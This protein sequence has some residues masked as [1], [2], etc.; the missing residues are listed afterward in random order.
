MG[1]PVVFQSD[2]VPGVQGISNTNDGVT[3][4]STSAFGVFA[5]SV[6]GIGLRAVSES[7]R[8]MEAQ[9]KQ[10]IAEGLVA[11]SEGGA[12]VLGIS[13]TGD[14]VVGQSNSAFGAFVH[15]ESG[16][17]LRATSQSGR[18]M[19]AQAKQNGEG[20]VGQSQG[21]DG[22]FGIS[23]T[24]VGVHGQGGRLAGLFE[25]DVQATGNIQ[26]NDVSATGKI[27]CD[28][29]VAN[30]VDCPTATITCFDVSIS[31][32]DCAEEFE[33]AGAEAV[34]PGTLMSFGIDGTLFPSSES[35]DS[36]VVGVISGAG[37]YKPGIVLDRRHGGNRVPIAL[38]GKVYCK[39]DAEYSAIEVG[40][41]LTT[42][43]TAGH[44]MKA[45]DPLKAFGS[46]IGKALRSKSDGRGMIPVLV[47]LQ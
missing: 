39:V 23:V 13:N 32:A 46:V 15:S 19:E 3:G 44:A 35:Y 45:A 47:A 21:G 16:V 12:G 14:G 34:Q 26:G 28:V 9:A 18:A 2:D 41:L 42:S 24:G 29:L 1:S 17:G 4:R 36:K 7:G 5:A 6:S 8:G 40:D 43:P 10:G 11:Q 20:V 22:V 25:G 31:N 38:L 37:E 30:K 33:L 27:Q